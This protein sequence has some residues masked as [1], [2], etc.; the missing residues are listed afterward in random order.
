MNAELEGYLTSKG[1]LPDL[2][3]I[4]NYALKNNIPYWQID[5]P[6]YGCKD[7]CYA[8]MNYIKE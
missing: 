7:T 4:Q 3:K 8:N 1:G 2:D 5:I 6:I